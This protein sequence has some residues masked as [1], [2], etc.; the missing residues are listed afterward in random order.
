MNNT[1]KEQRSE[2]IF[3]L[4]LIWAQVIGSDQHDH[5]ANVASLLD[6]LRLYCEE[7][8]VEI[9]QLLKEAK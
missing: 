9:D 4:M 8:G 7:Y 2:R 6:D 5:A 1:E 3:R